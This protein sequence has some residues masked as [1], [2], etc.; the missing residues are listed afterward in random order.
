MLEL[1][2]TFFLLAIL[3]FSIAFVFVR[4]FGR[5]LLLDHPNSRSSH[6]RPRSRAGGLVFGLVWLIAGWSFLLWRYSTGSQSVTLL[7]SPESN[8][9][10]FWFLS[11]AT[12]IW[13]NGLLDDFFQ[14]PAR[15]RIILQALGVAGGILGP[16]IFRQGLSPILLAL[17]L[18][19]FVYYINVFN[20]M[21]GTDGLAGSEAIFVLIVCAI[22]G[23]GGLLPAIL[24]AG[25]SVFLFWNFPRARIFMGDSGSNLLGYVTGYLLFRLFWQEPA[26]AVLIPVF[27]LSDATTTLLRR[28]WRGEPFYKAHNHHAY[29][30]IAR[31]YGHWSV[32]IFA[33][34]VNVIVMLI[35]PFL[36]LTEMYMDIACVLACY[37]LVGGTMFRLG[38][39]KPGPSSG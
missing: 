17:A 14:L 20:F 32:L 23:V 13:I 8:Q 12:L 10:I 7:G 21:D 31:R 30:H 26:A 24:A 35:I 2:D 38:A 11:G 39:G 34:I 29:Q 36:R 33:A 22:L 19:A 15:Y 16:D 1:H 6:T 4:R 28:I 3:V 27:F 25:L 5:G 18:I 37:L 9:L